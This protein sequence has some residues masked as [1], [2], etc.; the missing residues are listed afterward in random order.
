MMF[1]LGTNFD[2]L[3][4]LDGGDSAERGG[5]RSADGETRCE[6]RGE[7]VSSAEGGKYGRMICFFA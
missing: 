2:V 5:G 1:A 6:M 7:A 3:H 4:R